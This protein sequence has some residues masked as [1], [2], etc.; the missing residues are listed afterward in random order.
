[1]V[2]GAK[3]KSRAVPEGVDVAYGPMGGRRRVAA[4]GNSTGGVRQ[5]LEYTRAGEGARVSMIILHD[6]ANREYA[7]GPAQALPAT[8][9]WHVNPSALRR[10]DEVGLS[11]QQQEDPMEADL[12]VRAVAPD[13]RATINE[14][15]S[16]MIRSRL[17]N[18]LRSP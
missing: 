7:Y 2:T 16:K 18:L 5:M 3:G 6:D 8:E 15:R 4:F 12:R 9:A 11:H 10:G 17:C 14:S 1:M 13:T